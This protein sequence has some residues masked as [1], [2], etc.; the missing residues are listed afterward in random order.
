MTQPNIPDDNSSD[1]KNHVA[2]GS[3][4]SNH[5]ALN[6]SD[7]TDAKA[8]IASSVKTS[9]DVLNLKV[10]AYLSVYWIGYDEWFT[11]TLLSI[12]CSNQHGLYVRIGYDDE[13]VLTRTKIEDLKIWNEITRPAVLETNVDQPLLTFSE[14][15][16]KNT[17]EYTVNRLTGRVTL[18][19]S[20]G[21]RQSNYYIRKPHHR[22]ERHEQSAAPVVVSHVSSST[23][24]AAAPAVGDAHDDQFQVGTHVKIRWNNHRT[25]EG[26]IVNTFQDN[27]RKYIKVGYEDGDFRTHELAT[28]KIK[29][30]LKPW[31][32]KDQDFFDDNGDRYAFKFAT[33]E[34][35]FFPSTTNGVKQPRAKRQ[36]QSESTSS[37]TANASSSYSDPMLNNGAAVMPVI[38]A[39]T[40]ASS[41]P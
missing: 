22:I 39:Y 10:G 35:I 21:R 8:L 4:S 14:P 11:G 41:F 23:S 15:D 2:A 30:I 25:Y 27:G 7:N 24:S 29:A 40:P 5:A 3:S 1:D 17:D 20:S 13:E 19:T 38:T 9:K 6:N 33:N 31:D 26:V 16:E 37:L 36:R 32:G 28:L 18:T 34:I 12:K